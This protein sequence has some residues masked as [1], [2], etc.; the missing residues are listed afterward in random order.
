ME[1]FRDFALQYLG[2]VILM[3]IKKGKIRDFHRVGTDKKLNTIA[4]N[5]DQLD[6]S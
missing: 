5:Q 2:E 1:R 6:T 4:E 3:W